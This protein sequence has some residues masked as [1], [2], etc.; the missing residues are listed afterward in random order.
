M[1][2]LKSTFAKSQ[3]TKYIVI[4]PPS[5]KGDFFQKHIMI[6]NTLLHRISKDCDEK[7]A[8]FLGILINENLTWKYH[9][10]HINKKVS[11]ALFSLKQ[12]KH[13]LP[14]Q[15]MKTLYYALTHSFSSF[16]RDPSLG[17]RDSICSTSNHFAAKTGHPFNR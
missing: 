2:L 12:V 14:K 4:R 17:K 11:R 10:S 5:L 9:L 8:K 15:C 16:I 3:Q 6:E 1:V 13:F 7:A